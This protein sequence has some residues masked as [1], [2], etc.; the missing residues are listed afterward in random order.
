[1]CEH[2]WFLQ[3]QSQLFYTLIIVFSGYGRVEYYPLL[4]SEGS[5]YKIV[6]LVYRLLLSVCVLLIYF[7]ILTIVDNKKL[8]EV[9]TLLENVV[10]QLKGL[11]KVIAI[12]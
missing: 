5:S 3:S 9:K 11:F 4:I 1:M 2:G 7:Y 8:T 10:S 6:Q 12:V